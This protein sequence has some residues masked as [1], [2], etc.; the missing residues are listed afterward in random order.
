[1]EDP[2]GRKMVMPRILVMSE[3][4]DARQGEVTLDE[5]VS[6]ADMQSDHRAAQLIQRVG[7]AVHDADDADDAHASY[8]GGY[9]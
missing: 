3:P 7:W 2:T 8:A 9:R 4:T 1:L 6:S 5:C